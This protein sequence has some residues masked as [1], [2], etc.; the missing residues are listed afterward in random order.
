MP[1]SRQPY[2]SVVNKVRTVSRPR[3]KWGHVIPGAALAAKCMRG[4]HPTE[5]AVVL[6]AQGRDRD[7]FVRVKIKKKYGTPRPERRKVPLNPDQRM[8]VM[9]DFGV[10]VCVILW[11]ARPHA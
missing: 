9:Q 8:T 6:A 1:W 3:T 11:P 10:C 5:P 4:F 7:G 2:F